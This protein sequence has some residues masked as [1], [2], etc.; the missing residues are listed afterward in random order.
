MFFYTEILTNLF[1]LLVE[2]QK[3]PV[4]QPLFEFPKKPKVLPTVK[5]LNLDCVQA[6]VFTTPQYHIKDYFSA[7]KEKHVVTREYSRFTKQKY[8]IR[9]IT[10]LGCLNGMSMSERGA[11]S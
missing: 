1:S 4:N 10:S 7:L 9:D 5:N 11:L 3:K 8:S 6:N 2:K